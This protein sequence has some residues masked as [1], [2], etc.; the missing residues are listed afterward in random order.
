MEGLTEVRA[1]SEETIRNLLATLPYRTSCRL[2]W[3]GVEVHR[4]HVTTVE[5]PEHSLPQLAVFLPHVDKPF[6]AE[7]FV[8]GQPLAARFNNACVS[9]VPPG[10]TRRFR[11][12]SVAPYD[13]TAILIDPLTLTRIA[14]VQTGCDF[15]EIFPQF[16]IVDPLIRSIGMMLDAELALEHPNPRIYAES[17]VAA[18]AAHIF[19]K[20]AKSM[21]GD[22]R[23]LGTNWPQ[24]RRSL[25]HINENLNKDLHL[26]E[27]AAVAGMSKYHFAKSFREAIG[28][29]PHQYLVKARVEK[30][31][32]LLA[33]DAMSMEEV[34]LRVGYADKGQF[35]EQFL[36]IVG[37][38]PKRYR[39]NK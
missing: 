18:L 28:I 9:I 11:R 4:Y 37:T 19:A 27:L 29:P 26:S 35:A 22:M 34:A 20:Y 24:L 25:E 15:P 6:N 30:A 8:D 21:V 38:T 2:H 17:L 1:L 14:R 33:D 3:P 10:V 16:G 32:T 7:L 36:K 39:M 5:G 31:R 23:T 12:D 13:L